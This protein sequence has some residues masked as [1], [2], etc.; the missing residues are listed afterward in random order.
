MEQ[1]RRNF[2]KTA[3]AAMG[4]LS[5][6]SHSV[7]A[8]SVL[9]E[10]FLVDTQS[11]D[12]DA[13]RSQVEIIDEAEQTGFASV[14]G[15]EGDLE[16]YGLDFAPEIDLSL[17]P[18]AVEGASPEDAAGELPDDA[19]LDDVD[20]DDSGTPEPYPYQ[21]SKKEQN[22][23]DIHQAG[24]TGDGA[25]VAIVDSGI[26]AD[27]PELNVNTA[28]SGNYSEDDS[29]GTSLG[30]S[31]GTHCAGIAA[32]SGDRASEGGAYAVGVAPDAELLDMKVFPFK[33]SASILNAAETAIDR[34][35]DAINLSLGPASPVPPS[36]S[37]HL[38]ETAYQRLGEIAVE[39]DAVLVESAGNSD[40]N[41]DEFEPQTTNTGKG[42]HEGWLSV[43]AAGPHSIPDAP[44][45]APLPFIYPPADSDGDGEPDYGS[46]IPHHTPSYYTSYGPE[47]V[48][49]SAPGGNASGSGSLWDGVFSTLSSKVDGYGFIRTGPGGGTGI[50]GGS[51]IY[52]TL[53]GTSMA[54]PHVTGLVA[55]V[56]AQ[57]PDA[58]SDQIKE[59]IQNTAEEIEADYENADYFTDE[60]TTADDVGNAIL[61][62]PYDS[63]TF[64]GDGH[65]DIARAGQ[66]E[67]PFPG[68]VEVDGETVFPADPDDDG[69][70]EDVNGDGVVDM[71]DVELLYQMALYNVVPSDTEAFDFNGDGRFDMYDVQELIRQVE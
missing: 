32:A 33:S 49:V 36:I 17:E 5:I 12:T 62:D 71:D 39:N 24:I 57:N 56:K 40:I 27:H 67:I 47:S 16:G 14:S 51:G 43:S 2:I 21:W 60:P 63:E 44:S 4:G 10:Q 25:R 19:H 31:H 35:A 58:T 18:P 37:Q 55:V 26:D 1:T 22:V 23:S 11:T 30:S 15:S 8:E 7:V 45:D 29:I 28:L 54:A 38:S 6:A 61:E 41:I 9:E 13:W 53:H 69:L 20:V 52:G 42:T 64:R 46:I 59:H 48:D 65:I 34:G 50:Y 68:G 3:A 70:Y 66:K